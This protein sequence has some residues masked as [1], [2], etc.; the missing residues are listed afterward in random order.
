MFTLIHL[1]IVGALCFVVGSVAVLVYHGKSLKDA[2]AAELATLK[3]DISTL[4]DRLDPSAAGPV[5][6]AG[7]TTQP[8]KSPTGGSV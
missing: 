4:K 2:I 1:L 5:P 7:S 3:S 8:I 6:V